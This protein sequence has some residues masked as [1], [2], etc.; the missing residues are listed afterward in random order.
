M[1]VQHIVWLKPNEGVSNTFMDKLLASVEA[2]KG[3]VPGIVDI[4]TG[5]NFTDRAQGY[6]YGLI[7]TLTNKEA[8]SAYIDH[9]LHQTVGAQLKANCTVVAMDYEH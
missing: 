3:Q 6:T 9:S 4:S 5:R 8:L 1:S 2:L 7:V